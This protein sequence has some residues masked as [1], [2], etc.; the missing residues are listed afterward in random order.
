MTKEHI[1]V[2]CLDI[3]LTAFLRMFRGFPTIFRIFPKIIWKARRMFPNIFRRLPTLGA[4]FFLSLGRHTSPL[5]SE[6]TSGIQSKDCLRLSR[7]TRRCFDDTPTNLIT[8]RTILETNLISLKPL[9]SSSVRIWY[10]SYSDVF[11][12]E[13]LVS[14]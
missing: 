11:Y 1:V 14:I 9:I 4:G 13:T 8:L 10:E 6:K 12:S 3:L 7:K 5:A 2:Y